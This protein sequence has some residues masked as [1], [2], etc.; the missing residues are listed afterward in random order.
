MA[1]LRAVVTIHAPG[2]GG[3]PSAGHV[4][5]ATVNASWT[6]SSAMSMSPRKRIRVATQRPYSR[7]KTA[8]TVTAP[9]SRVAP[10]KVERLLVMVRAALLVEF[11]EAELPEL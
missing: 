5:A 10:E 7:R 8:S 9:E 2:W 4:A 11:V 3:T 1:R 6:T